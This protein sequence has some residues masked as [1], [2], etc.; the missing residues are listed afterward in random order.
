MAHMVYL[1][2]EGRILD[3]L[4]IK[5]FEAICDNSMWCNFNTIYNIADADDL[6]YVCTNWSDWRQ[7]LKDI[8]TNY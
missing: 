7:I 6:E 3:C 5:V 1:V 2:Y 8:A 4:P